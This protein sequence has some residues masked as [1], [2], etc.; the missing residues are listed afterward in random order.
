MIDRETAISKFVLE[1]QDRQLIL[2]PGKQ[3]VANGDWQRCDVSNKPNGKNDGSYLLNLDGRVPFGF[4]RNWC[5]G[6]DVDYWRGEPGRPLNE[7]E[8]EEFDRYVA[9]ARAEAE[10]LA[11][12]EAI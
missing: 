8:R 9:K 5:D 4:Y 2:A 10:K 1:M 6:K 7:A 3:L 11:A 12:E